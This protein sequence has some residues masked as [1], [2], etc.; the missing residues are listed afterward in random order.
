MLSI[1]KH[2]IFAT[3]T[4]G[5]VESGF[6]APGEVAQKKL[7]AAEHVPSWPGELGLIFTLLSLALAPVG[8]PLSFPGPSHYGPV[9]RGHHHPPGTPKRAH[10]RTA[11]AALRCSFRTATGHEVH[12][13]LKSFPKNILWPQGQQYTKESSHDDRS[14]KNPW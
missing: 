14:G 1:S 12:N 6:S 5:S 9:R 10:R 4:A 11:Q 13:P 8:I 3:P 2:I 7:Y